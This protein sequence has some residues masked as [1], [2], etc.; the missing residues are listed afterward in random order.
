MTIDECCNSFRAGE[1]PQKQTDH[2]QHQ[3]EDGPQDLCPRGCAAL[4]C[5]HD[6]PDVQCKNDD[7]DNASVLETHFGTPSFEAGCASLA[8]SL[9]IGLPVNG[10]DGFCV[11]AA[12]APEIDAERLF[13]SA[14]WS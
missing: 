8:P 3:Y 9:Q 13:R 1:Q 2:G 4:E 12:T 11:P 7:P 14:R 10:W 5:R 6:R